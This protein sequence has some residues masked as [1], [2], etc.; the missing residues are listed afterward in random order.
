[1]QWLHL[2]PSIR[3]CCQV[4]SMLIHGDAA[5]SGQGVVYETFHLSHLPAYQT[6]GTIHVVV[7]NQVLILSRLSLACFWYD[8]NSLV[9][10]L[11]N[12]HIFRFLSYWLI[13]RL[14][15]WKI[16]LFVKFKITCLKIQ[17]IS[18][19]TRS[20]SGSSYFVLVPYRHSPVIINIIIVA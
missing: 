11:Q 15:C 10:W 16:V 12:N 2:V 5:F 14:T 4:M 3:R 17:H 20:T 19:W 9:R 8:D 18:V 1:M 6:G 7:N 13:R